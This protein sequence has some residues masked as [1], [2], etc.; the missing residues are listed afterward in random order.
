M[1]ELREQILF[2]IDMWEMSMLSAQRGLY[3]ELR[4][5]L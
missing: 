5:C 4:R 1:N 3:D 2:L